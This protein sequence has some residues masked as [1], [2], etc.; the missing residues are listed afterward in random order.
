MKKWLFAFLILPCFL[1]AQHLELGLQGGASGYLGDLMD[2]NVG[3]IVSELHPSVGAFARYNV[4]DWIA[5]KVGFNYGQISGNDAN[6]DNQGR[7]DRNLSFRSNILEIGLHAEIN[8][9]GYQPYN[10]ERTFS[11]YVFIGVAMFRFNPQAEYQG[12]W[13]DL[14]PLGT[15]GQGMPDYPNREFYQLTEFSIPAGLGFKYAINDT[16]NLG[17]EF[18]MRKTFTDYLDDVSSTYVDLEALRAAR[19]PSGDVAVALSDRHLISLREDGTQRGD[20]GGN[21]DWYMIGAVSISYNFLDT[22]L[23]GSRGRRGGKMGCPTF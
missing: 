10:L 12:Q 4:N 22:G 14:Q 15:E 20:S 18:G 17:V 9:M 21:Q 1:Q 7:V 11:P 6:A 3:N 19:G 8:I 2:N 13:Y 5:A 23:A 16:W